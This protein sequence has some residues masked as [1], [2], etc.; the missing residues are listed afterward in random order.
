MNITTTKL[1]QP[2]RKNDSKTPK[3]IKPV[4]EDSG[5]FVSILFTN[6]EKSLL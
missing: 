5:F 3:S 2:K 1:K 4:K 6:E